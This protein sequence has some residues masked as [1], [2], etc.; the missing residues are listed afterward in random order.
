MGQGPQKNSTFE[1]HI[2]QFGAIAFCSKQSFDYNVKTFF[3][4][5][6]VLRQ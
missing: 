1:K 6:V 4:D 2:K 3:Q 5:F